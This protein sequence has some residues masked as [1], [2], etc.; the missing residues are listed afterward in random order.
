MTLHRAAPYALVLPLTLA[1]GCGATGGQPGEPDPADS[2]AAAF[3]PD[4][5]HVLYIGHSFGRP[6]AEGL[7]D[8]VAAAG[9]EGHTSSVVFRGGAGGAPQALW[10]DDGPNG[11]Q[12]EAL[13]VLATG[14]VDLMVMICCSLSFLEE[15][16]LG[17]DPGIG[18]WMDAALEA[19]PDTRFALAMPWPDYPEVDPDGNRTY[20]DAAAYASVWVDEALPLWHQLI[21]DLRADH[22]GVEITNLPHGRAALDLRTRFEAGDLPEVEAL[23]SATEA[24]VFNDVKGHAD[25]VLVDLGGLVWLGVLYGL[26]PGQYPP[27]AGYDTDLV[28]MAERIVE[29]DPYVW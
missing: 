3:P 27:P 4:G 23:S 7:P 18:L 28:E 10:D 2:G 16:T 21:A 29:E 12:R 20:P 11:A 14:E 6:F 24:S 25:D 5:Q 9:I 22:P 26:E 19:N 15:A 17:T 13:D 8:L 1:L